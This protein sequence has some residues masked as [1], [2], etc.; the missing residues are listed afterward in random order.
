MMDLG[1][2]AR[3]SLTAIALLCCAFAGVASA[4]VRFDFE[5]GD[6]QGW[7]IMEGGF[8]EYINDRAQFHHGAR[9]YNKHGKFFFTTL[10]RADGNPDDS[11][12]GVVE[13]PVFVLTGPEMSLLVGGGKHATTYV[14]LCTVD[15]AEVRKAQGTAT[16]RMQEI[17]W[18]APELVGK[19]VFVRAVDKH[20][21]GWGHITLDDFR[22]EGSIDAKATDARFRD[23]IHLQAVREL[24]DGLNRLNLAGMRAAVTDLMA[25]CG[26]RYPQGAKFLRQLGELEKQPPKLRKAIDAGKTD[27]RE[28]VAAVL[29]TA[30]ELRR[31][32]LLA[33]PLV[34]GQPILF[35]VRPQY[36]PDHHNTAT[37]FQVGEINEASFVGGGAVKVIDF[38]DAGRVTTLIDVPEGIARDPEIDF[39]GDRVVFSMRRDAK[40]D[41]HIYEMNADGSDLRQLTRAERVSDVDPLYLPDGGIAF[42]STREPKYC[43]CNRHIMAN[44]FRMGADG[45]NIHQI[46]KSTLFEG[47][48]A[49]LP[50]GRILYDRWEYVDRNFGDAQ[51]LWTVNPDGTGQAVYWGNNTWSPGGVIDARPIPFTQE[52][53]SIFGSCHDRPWGALAVLDRR[54]GLDDR[55]PVVRTWPANA[56]DLVW[57]PGEK[58]VGEYGFDIFKQVQPKYE[59]PY[60]LCDPANPRTTGKYFLCSRTIGKGEV[61]GLYL[62]DVFGNEVLLHVEEPGCFDPMPLAPHPRPG[63]IPSRRDFKN[64]DGQFYVANVYEGTHMAGVE[65]GSVKYLRVVESPEKRYWTHPNW[66]GQGVHCPAMNWHDFNNKRILGTVPVEADGSAYFSVPADKFVYFQLLDERGMMVQSMR[67][68]TVVQSGERT[69]C[70]GCH[71]HRLEAPGTATAAHSAPG[72]TVPLAMKREPSALTGWHGEPRLFSYLTEVQP[73]LDKHCVRCHDYS[74]PAGER[75]NLAGDQTLFFNASYTEL[76]KRGLTGAVGAGPADTQ[77]A[78]AWG[79]H[80]SKLVKTLLKKHSGVKLSPEEFDR[81]VT[82]VDINAP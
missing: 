28:R 24:E 19:K 82:W 59:D 3:I 41:Y 76:W 26:D 56:I 42:S 39:D 64:D 81:I 49:L 23:A 6:L 12:T 73:V 60:P 18:S 80:S 46:G 8:G 22:A 75:L 21:G 43:M 4:Q 13:S 34:S 58:K 52:V 10:E 47:H 53:V 78:Y 68:G 29:E 67:S 15:G 61:M 32:A 14:A 44:L 69:G 51:G 25:T 16:E 65:P 17:T 48:G 5:D 54:R 33:N 57:Q 37:L 35:V 70:V 1:R 38:A 20:T 36:K 63:A 9:P 11:F 50:D 79:S 40:D 55:G 7:R 74:G 2:P 77:K 45:D 31:T 27:T 71:E 66:G 62:I 72:G 30:K